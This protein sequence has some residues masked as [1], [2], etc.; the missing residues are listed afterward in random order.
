ML[1]F[2][3][4]GLYLY[5]IILSLI[6]LFFVRLEVGLIKDIGNGRSDA[7]EVRWVGAVVN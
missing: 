1:I 6:S 5:A 2:F 4:R 3:P 7:S